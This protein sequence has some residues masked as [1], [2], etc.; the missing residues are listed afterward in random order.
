VGD[1]GSVEVVALDEGQGLQSGLGEVRLN[2][3]L[4]HSVQAK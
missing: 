2:E 1:P 4:L 3:V